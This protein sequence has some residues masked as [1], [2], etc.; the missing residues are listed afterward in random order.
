MLDTYCKQA[1]ARKKFLQA[2]SIPCPTCEAPI[3]TSKRYASDIRQLLYAQAEEMTQADEH[4]QLPPAEINMVMAAMSRAG[5]RGWTKNSW[6]ICQRGHPF[7]VGECGAAKETGWCMECKSKVGLS[8]YTVPG[9]T[10]RTPQ[11]NLPSSKLIDRSV[12][13]PPQSRLEN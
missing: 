12:K 1:F 4:S 2:R 6:Y 13:M 11:W 5:Y 9:H 3:A 10:G 7:Y 8:T